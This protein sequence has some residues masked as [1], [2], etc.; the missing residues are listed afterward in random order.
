MFM[1]EAK[2]EYH[3]TWIIAKC[4]DALVDYYRWFYC[5]RKWIKLMRPRNGAHISLARGEDEGIMEGS[6]ERN[7]DGEIIQFNYSNDLI[8]RGNYIWMPVW[9]ESLYNIREKVGLKREP[10]LPFHMTVGRT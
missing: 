9:G 4:D 6:W 8:E 10:I 1:S 7:L 2:V 3:T 5:K